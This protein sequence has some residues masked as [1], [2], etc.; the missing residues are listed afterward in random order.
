MGH[1]R[2]AHTPHGAGRLVEDRQFAQCQILVPRTGMTQGARGVQLGVEERNPA[3][4][5]E[6]QVVVADSGGSHQVGD[7]LFVHGGVLAHVEPAQMGAERRHRSSDGLDEALRE[8]PGAVRCER[9]DHDVE[10]VLQFTQVRV[11]RPRIRRR[12]TG[13]GLLVVEHGLG[14]GVEAGMH[15]A[16][17][18]PIRLVGAERRVVT[19]RRGQRIQLG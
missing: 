7:D 19:R 14:V 10:I 8:R 3:G 1:D 5:V 9:V 4:L 2:T 16:Q 15:P 11:C 17:R 18:P 6:C 12:G 13:H